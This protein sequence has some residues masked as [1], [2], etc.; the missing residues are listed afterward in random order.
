MD[1]E[2]GTVNIKAKANIRSTRGGSWPVKLDQRSLR[3]LSC[4]CEGYY[5]SKTSPRSCRHMRDATAALETLG[6]E[7]VT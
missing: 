7:V 3:P 5:Y 6:L 2:Y 4:E 1:Q